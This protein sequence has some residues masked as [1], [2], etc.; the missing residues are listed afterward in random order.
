MEKSLK[1]HIIPTILAYSKQEF[2]DKYNKIKE[3]GYTYFQIDIV[4][5][6]FTGFPKTWATPQ[7][8]KTLDLQIP[9]EIDSME[10]HPEKSLLAWKQA[11]ATRIYIHI[12]AVKNPLKI[13]EKVKKLGLEAGIALNP[14]TPPITLSLI[15]PSIHA[16]LL[17]GV[18]PGKGGQ[19]FQT[20][21][22][23]KISAIRSMGWKKRIAIDGGVTHANALRI[24]R[25]G[26]DILASGT[27]A[28]SKT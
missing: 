5:T 20:R 17:L 4:D 19:K 10:C 25:T 27:F 12:E 22:L 24:L 1:K 18:P 11:G 14:E 8:V 28:Y 7:K 13:I 15:L 16:I 21:V 23:K 6:A 9:F 2:L 3:N 26:A